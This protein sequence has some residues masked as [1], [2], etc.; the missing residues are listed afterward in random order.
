[1]KCKTQRSNIL[2]SDKFSIVYILRS[3]TLSMGESC[4][5]AA[6]TISQLAH[7][8]DQPGLCEVRSYVYH[9]CEAGPVSPFVLIFALTYLCSFVAVQGVQENKGYDSTVTFRPLSSSAYEEGPCRHMQ[10]ERTTAQNSAFGKTLQGRRSHYNKA[11]NFHV[12]N[13]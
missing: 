10:D 3:S 9:Q 4:G 7:W 11:G 6:D 5:R 13:G 12:R 2:N 8:A 1:M